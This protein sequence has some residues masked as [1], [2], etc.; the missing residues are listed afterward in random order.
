MMIN[1]NY[2]TDYFCHSHYQSP[3]KVSSKHRSINEFGYAEK[4]CIC[5][6][7]KGAQNDIALRGSSLQL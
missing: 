5:A 4:V 7:Q 6:L 2:K 3:A 1:G